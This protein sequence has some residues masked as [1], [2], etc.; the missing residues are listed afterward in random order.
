MR[1]LFLVS[2]ISISAL[3]VM[4]G[5]KSA[6]DNQRELMSNREREITAG[7]VKKE[8][9]KG[10]S[11]AEVAEALGSPNI[12]TKDKDGRETWVYDKIAQ[13]ASYSES[14][15][16]LFLI[17]GGVSNQTGAASTTQRTLTVVIKFDADDKVTE[18]SYHQ[19]KF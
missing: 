4:T 7:I 3:G 1:T 5:C 15:N 16:S 17:I 12:T 9:R 11:G 6:A 8:I 13:E 19:S 18:Y 14:Q 10:M 2:L